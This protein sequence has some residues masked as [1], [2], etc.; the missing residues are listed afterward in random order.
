MFVIRER[1][2]AH[3]VDRPVHVK[4]N[5]LYPVGRIVNILSFLPYKLHFLKRE[6]TCIYSFVT[7]Y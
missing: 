4:C 5:A 3:P 6:I 2:F 1:L 7:V